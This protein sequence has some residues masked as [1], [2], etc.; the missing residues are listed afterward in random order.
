VKVKKQVHIFANKP[1]YKH[2]VLRTMH[3]DVKPYKDAY[4]CGGIDGPTPNISWL[5]PLPLYSLYQVH[6]TDGIHGTLSYS[7]VPPAKKRKK[8]AR[9]YCYK[10][11]DNP[12][13]LYL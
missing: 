8:T 2:R 12:N 10:Y 1:R 13:A 9:I 11:V 4:Y 7:C 5:K 6:T 3:W